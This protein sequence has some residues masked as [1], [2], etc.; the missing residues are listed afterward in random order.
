MH[1]VVLLDGWFM[2][3][4]MVFAEGYFPNSASFATS[5]TTLMR[6]IAAT[7]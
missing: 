2:Q 3:W 1:F 6:A 7:K 4:P 5:T